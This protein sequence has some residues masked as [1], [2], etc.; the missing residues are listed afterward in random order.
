MFWVDIKLLVTTIHGWKGTLAK[1]V[2]CEKVVRSFVWGF[3][4]VVNKISSSIGLLDALSVRL[5]IFGI[6]RPTIATEI[7][8]T[9]GFN[10]PTDTTYHSP[11][12]VDFVFF[13][14]FLYFMQ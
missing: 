10:L 12:F 6:G 11:V 3:V 8:W 7:I 2:M 1:L 4:M 14:L 5:F 13:F 9:V